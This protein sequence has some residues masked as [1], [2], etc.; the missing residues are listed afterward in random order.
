MRIAAF[1]L[2]I[3]MTMPA[4]A[5]AQVGPKTQ[6]RPPS[7]QPVEGRPSDVRGSPP[8]SGQ[9]YLGERAPDFEL[10]GPDGAREAPHDRLYRLAGE[11]LGLA[12]RGSKARPP[13]H[14]PR[15]GRRDRRGDRRRW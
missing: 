7:D 11:L 3:L 10:D 8:I 12:G 2:V 14:P 13:E 5:G 9:V 15:L 6:R 1:A 4:G